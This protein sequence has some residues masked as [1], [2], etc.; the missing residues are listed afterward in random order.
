M[1]PIFLVEDDPKIVSLL[2]DHLEKYDYVVTSCRDFSR[3]LDEF[4]RVQPA[5]VLLDI[6]LPHFDGFYWCRR[7][8]AVSTCPILFISAR[9]STM[10]QVMALEN[11]ADDYIPKPFSFEV[12]VAKVGSQV[13][14]A[15][16]EYAIQTSERTMKHAGLV[17]YPERLQVTFG[18]K[19]ITLSKKEALLLECLLER[20]DRVVSRE[21]LLEALWDDV[22]FVEENTLNVNIARV[23]KK[24]QELGLPDAVETVR[25]AGYRF[26]TTWSNVP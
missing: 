11:G 19:T 21:R 3:V 13:R 18:S 26:T 14:R 7:I 17:L 9:D 20:P 10:D 6:T 24:L 8:R 25:S 15:Y 12:V 16:G 5:L 2:Q 23:R 22:D 4:E 1:Y